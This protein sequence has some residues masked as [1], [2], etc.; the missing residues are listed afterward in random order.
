MPMR[1][2]PNFGSSDLGG[3]R[4]FDLYTEDERAEERL[5]E[6]KRGVHVF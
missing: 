2:S 1:C 4:C 6:Q 5:E 3:D